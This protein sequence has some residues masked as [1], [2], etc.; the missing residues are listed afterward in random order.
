M[1][2]EHS[3]PNKYILKYNCKICNGCPHGNISG[4]CKICNGCPH[5]YLKYNCRICYACKHFKNRLK[6][7]ICKKNNTINNKQIVIHEQKY[8]ESFELQELLKYFQ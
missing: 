1:Y 8:E 3:N 2:C 4:R 7:N 5:G 6:C